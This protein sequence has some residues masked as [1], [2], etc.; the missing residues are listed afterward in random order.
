MQLYEL[1]AWCQSFGYGLRSV[2]G[3]SLLPARTIPYDGGAPAP[4]QRLFW[5]PFA[6]LYHMELF[7]TIILCCHR[8]LVYLLFLA[9]R[10]RLLP[11]KSSY[12]SI[13]GL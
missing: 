9:H 1:P 7:Y 6:C 8:Q 13:L 2:A 3:R 4:L 12:I 11:I 5:V 10:P